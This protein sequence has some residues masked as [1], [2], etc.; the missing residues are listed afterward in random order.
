MSAMCENDQHY[1]TT[2]RIVRESRRK[3]VTFVK[4]LSDDK[5]APPQHFATSGDTFPSLSF[6]TGGHPITEFSGIQTS[7]D[8]ADVLCIYVSVSLISR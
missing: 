3:R 1:P 5:L 7:S 8:S 6:T 2:N 4:R